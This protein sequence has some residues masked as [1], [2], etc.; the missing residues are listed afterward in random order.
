V[1]GV[2]TF[3]PQ[4]LRRRRAAAGLTQEQ[5]AVAAELDAT[6][7]SHY[8]AGRRRPDAAVLRR[9]AAALEVA[10]AD[11]LRTEP[12]AGEA[13]SLSTLRR[14]AGLS[15]AEVAERL[16]IRA[17]TYSKIERGAT[18]LIAPARVAALAGM[19]GVG[20]S[21]VLAALRRGGRPGQPDRTTG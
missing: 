19:F 4:L 12:A 14:Q 11:L 8:E 10:V 15:Q 5:L 13:P 2:P 16:G 1:R 17:N 3:D 20:D 7:V 9:L 21:E 6:A 18:G